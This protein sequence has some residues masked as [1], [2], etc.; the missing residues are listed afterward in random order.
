MTMTANNSQ[1]SD[2]TG[3]K[4]ADFELSH[5]RIQLT[6]IFLSLP[7]EMLSKIYLADFYTEFWKLA[8]VAQLKTKF[9]DDEQKLLQKIFELSRRESNP[10][11]RQFLAL[12]LLVFDRPQEAQS[13]MEQNLWS[14]QLRQDFETFTKWYRLTNE[15]LTPRARAV[16]ERNEQISAFLKKK[17]SALI[18][19]YSH[20][21]INEKLCPRVKTED[22]QIYFCWLQGEENL[23]PVVR[24]CY[25]SLKMNAGHYKIVFIDE[26]NFSR[27]VDISPHIMKKFRAGKI[28]RTHFSDILR[29]NL[30]ERYGGLWLDSTVLVTE[31]LENH[32]E[33][34]E[35]TYFTQKYYHD[36]NPLNPFVRSFGCYI[37]YA[38]WAGFIQG[39]SVLHNPLFA[40][41]KKF[42][43]KYWRD[44]D[45]P[46]V[47]DF[48]DFIIDF[49]YENNSAVHEAM[50]AV[51][52]NNDNVWTLLRNLDKPYNEYPYDKILAGNFLNKLS[53]KAS[54]DMTT[55]DTVFRKIQQRYAPETIA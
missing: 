26:K 19:K 24:C 18:E 51:P 40:F 7:P 35:Q 12:L 5:R 1:G 30:L 9:D 10:I 45:E 44:F 13:L 27:Y 3:G 17:Y 20:A 43:S 49:A 11:R 33:L 4:G 32:R 23:P 21:V 48:M 29:V 31:P 22:Y 16:I 28:T 36:K 54:I 47:Y 15:T 14:A 42:F 37:S 38:R 8:G 52:I 34:F 2:S 55:P 39:T 25:N 41:E 50:D 46:I 6:K 53:W